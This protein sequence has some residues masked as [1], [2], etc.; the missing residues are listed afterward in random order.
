MHLFSNRLLYNHHRCP[1]RWIR[2]DES[3]ASSVSTCRHFSN[4]SD[5]RLFDDATCMGAQRKCHLY[6]ERDESAKTIVSPIL[7]ANRL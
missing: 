7:F 2:S 5:D 1:P 3:M 4:H 6:K